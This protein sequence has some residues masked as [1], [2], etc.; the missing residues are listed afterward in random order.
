M[1]FDPTVP[2]IH[3][4]VDAQTRPDPSAPTGARPFG[5]TLGAVARRLRAL[6]AAVARTPRHG[7]DHPR[8]FGATDAELARLDR[9]PM[10]PS[11]DELR[12]TKVMWNQFG[13]RRL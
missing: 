13:V 8:A 1:F 2:A 3:A 5:A 9:A 7:A 11:A 6:G 12:W 10:V 4:A